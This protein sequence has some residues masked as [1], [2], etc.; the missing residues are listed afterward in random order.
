MKNIPPLLFS[1]MRSSTPRIATAWLI[2]RTDGPRFGFTTSDTEFNYNGDAY[3]ST[4]FSPSAVVSKADAS[5][6]NLEVRVLMSST[7]TEQDLRAGVW[8][9][10]AVQ[11]FWIC[12]FYPEW[13]I[14]PLRVGTFGEVV[15]KSGQFTVS[16]QSTEISRD[17]G[18]KA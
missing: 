11:V 13:G 16:G 14:C 15:V 7:I 17:K 8:N 4:G 10:A 6:D 12:P 9:N 2:L 1:E 18:P 5:V 3:Y